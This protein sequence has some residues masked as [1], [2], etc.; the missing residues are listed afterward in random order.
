MDDDIRARLSRC[1]AAVF[2]DLDVELIGDASAGSMPSWDSIAHATLVTLVEEEFAVEL[3]AEELE[4][5][6][7]FDAFL[8]RLQACNGPA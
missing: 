2:P 8:R 5:L 1:F 4:H 3:D 6:T 7:S